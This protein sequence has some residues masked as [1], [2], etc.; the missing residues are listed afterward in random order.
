MSQI[1]S[2]DRPLFREERL[3]TILQLLLKEDK[4]YV[5]N[6]AELFD[7]SES[8]IRNDLAEL[9]SRGLVRRTY[10]GAILPEELSRKMVLDN[11]SIQSRTITYQKEKEAIGKAAAQLV[12]DGDTI[13]IDGGSTTLYVA[14]YLSTKRD[15]KIITNA[16]NLATDLL[17]IPNVEIF[18]TG[19]VL[20]QRYSQLLGEI[21]VEILN[22]FH[23]SKA[24][25][26]I[27]GISVRGGLNATDQQVAAIKRKIINRS[28][29]V[30]IVCDHSK[31]ERIC[32]M[33]IAPIS[34][35]DYII[36]DSGAK[37]SHIEAIQNAGA[38]V[39]L[40]DPES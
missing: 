33:P 36:T 18:F 17:A 4:V 30:I 28:D 2:E 14:R 21:T 13:M 10:G 20:D 1:K 35:V 11:S 40:V 34:D 7:V 5:T 9:Q 8:S 25:L 16:I 24:I 6:L 3:K 38:K 12:S 29:E 23:T 32:L 31:I 37:P 39:I 22:R 15:L 26:G 19:G 27:D